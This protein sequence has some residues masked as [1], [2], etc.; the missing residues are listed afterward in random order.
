MINIYAE[1]FAR[2]LWVHHSPMLALC[3]GT[4]QSPKHVSSCIGVMQCIT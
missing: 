2:V 3:L 4:R 1:N